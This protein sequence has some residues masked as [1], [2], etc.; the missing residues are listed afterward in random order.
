M[1][2]GIEYLRSFTHQYLFAVGLVTLAVVLFLP[3][4]LG[5]LVDRALGR[6]LAERARGLGEAGTP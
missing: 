6:G 2:L 1:S 3:Q 5:G 4:G